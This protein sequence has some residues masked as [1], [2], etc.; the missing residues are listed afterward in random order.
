LRGD[1]GWIDQSKSQ[2]SKLAFVQSGGL[3]IEVCFISNLSDLSAYQKRKDVLAQ[4]LA[5]TVKGIVQ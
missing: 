3:I 5:E 2:H 1:A 4:V